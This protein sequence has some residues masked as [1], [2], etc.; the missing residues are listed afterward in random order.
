MD[1]RR[2]AKQEVAALAGVN[3]QTLTKHVHGQRPC[4]LLAGLPPPVASPR[5]AKKLWIRQDILDWLAAQRTFVAA[6]QNSKGQVF[7]VQAIAQRELAAAEVA[8]ASLAVPTSPRR[9]RGRPRKV[10]G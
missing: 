7:G 4:H 6:A 3:L 5:G 1:L 10:G 9:G 2:I 8:V